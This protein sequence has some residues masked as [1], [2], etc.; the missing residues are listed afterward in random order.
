MVAA[1]AAT[2][3][4]VVAAVVWAAMAIVEMVVIMMGIAVVVMV[5]RGANCGSV[6]GNDSGSGGISRVFFIRPCAQ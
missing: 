5:G 6:G 1:P 2:L 4:V 3:V